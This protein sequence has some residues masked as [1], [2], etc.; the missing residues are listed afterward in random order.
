MAQV[1]QL[2][3]AQE[4][5][6]QQRE[7]AERREREVRAADLRRAPLADTAARAHRAITAPLAHVRTMVNMRVGPLPELHELAV[8]IKETGLLHPPLVRA[9][10]GQDAAYE[11]LAGRRRFGAMALLDD[12]DGAREDWRFTVVEGITRRE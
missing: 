6:A 8:S 5:V 3:E 1:D 11:L 7:E 4:Q 10:G 12:A 9:T 2:Q